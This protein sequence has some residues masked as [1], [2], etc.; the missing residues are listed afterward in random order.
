LEYFLQYHVRLAEPRRA[1]VRK[2]L[3]E[4]PGEIQR[5]QERLPGQSAD[6][7]AKDQKRIAALTAQLKEFEQES[8]EFTAEA[9]DRLPAKLKNLHAKAFDTNHRDPNYRR[10]MQVKYREGGEERTM[11]APQGDVLYQ[12]RQDVANGTLPTVS[13]IVGSEMFSDHPNAPWYGAW[14]ISEVIKILTA[15]PKVWQKTI[16]ILTYD[17]NDGFFDHV[18]PF[19]APHPRRPETGRV[20]AGI[21]ASLEYV[22]LEQDMKSKPKSQARDSALGLGYRVPM[23]IASP[24]SR[25]GC[26]CSQ[27]FDHTSPLLFLE[28]FLSH[29][30][31][32]DVKE[33]NINQW[34]RTVCGDLTSA[35]QAPDAVVPPLPFH[36]RDRF[37]QGIHHAQYQPVPTGFRALSAEEV[38]AIRKDPLTTPLLPKQEPGRRR[39]APLPYQLV[40][41][42]S[43]D[44]QHK[45]LVLE[46]RADTERFGKR[47]AGAAFI[48]YAVQPSGDFTVRNYAVEPGAK[49]EDTWDM[50]SFADCKY[51]LIVAGP[52]G[53]LREYHGFSDEP[54][55]LVLFD[56][57]RRPPGNDSHDHLPV[58]LINDD[59]AEK[60]MHIVD[61]SY[62]SPPRKVAVPTGRPLSI[63]IDTKP[64]FGW[65][66]F[67]VIIPDV[68]GFDW[69]FAGRYETGTWGFTDP[70]MDRRA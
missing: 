32:R 20:S 22:E 26:V 7:K 10:L 19:V 11:S 12:L 70:A 35:F 34:R 8:R 43:H 13:W 15:N 69:R 44:R 68:S 58:T 6:A 53:F 30:I 16:F 24:W 56:E 39:S 50:S 45:R 28:K 48:V 1:F 3:T 42:L 14:Y 17:E 25:G 27:V 60:I 62:G 63:A 55:V 66:D 9:F 54:A 23:I 18:P 2:R 37:L 51:H 41:N 36:D 61:R 40:A 29:K 5:L 57:S 65:Y 67:S 38:A 59:H 52:N 31:G 4:I 49:V 46:L 64:S 33:P 47:S 21:D